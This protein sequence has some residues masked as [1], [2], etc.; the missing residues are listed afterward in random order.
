MSADR[1]P[2]RL[3]LSSLRARML[4]ALLIFLALW[5]GVAFLF[6]PVVGDLP[7]VLI[8]AQR[9]RLAIFMAGLSALAILLVIWWSHRLTG[10]LRAMTE[11]ARHGS[12]LR[13]VNSEEATPLRIPDYGAR[14]DELGQLSRA[15]RDLVATFEDRAS[16]SEAFAADVAHEI[17]N[18]LASLHAAAEALEQPNAVERYAEI[19]ALISEDV[20]RL[21]RLLAEISTVTRLDAALVAE[22]AASFDLIALLQG[23]A[24]HFHAEAARKGVDLITDLPPGPLYLTGL[25][26]RLAQVVSNLVGNALSFCVDGDAVRIW[27]RR[28]EGQVLIVV[29]DTG[30]GIPEIA[31]TRIFRRFYSHRPSGASG[32]HSGLGLAISQQI[33]DAHGGVIWAEN[34]RPSE[35]DILSDPLGARF[36]VGLPL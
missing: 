34:I 35:V 32:A 2:R 8:A 14:C 30:P 10:P 5:W 1:A 28:R 4:A 27:V 7:A 31:L 17:R 16:A 25:E 18:P 33:V 26:E 22:R 36:V 6:L 15:L 11:A 12:G 23:M 3:P 19:S 20:R 9:A 13:R 24:A 21:D 29:E